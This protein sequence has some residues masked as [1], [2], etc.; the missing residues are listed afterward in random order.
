MSSEYHF[1]EVP[2]NSCVTNESNSEVILLFVH[3]TYN[4]YKIILNSACVYSV[5][6]TCC[7]RVVKINHAI[8]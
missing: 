2:C 3:A 7:L 5:L 1:Y 4:L 6:L 8:N